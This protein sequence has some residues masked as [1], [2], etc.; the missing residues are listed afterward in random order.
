MAPFDLPLHISASH[1]YLILPVLHYKDSLIVAAFPCEE[2][3]FIPVTMNEGN[4]VHI[5]PYQTLTSKI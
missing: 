5:T 1:S 3:I 4:L 2:A